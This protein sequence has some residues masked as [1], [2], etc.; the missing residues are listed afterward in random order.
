[1]KRISTHRHLSTAAEAMRSEY[2]F[3]YRKARLNRFAG[4]VGT[5]R[6]VVVLDP[7]VCAVFTTPESVN[8]VLRALINAMPRRA[9]PK[10]ARKSS[11]GVLV[12]PSRSE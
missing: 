9:K 7:D 11:P 5:K 3:D 6:L 12:N 8:R 4:R 10:A 2:H 1:M